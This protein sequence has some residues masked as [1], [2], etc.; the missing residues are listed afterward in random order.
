M[1]PTA[2][3]LKFWWAALFLALFVTANLIA[4]TQPKSD[5]SID[6]KSFTLENGM[7][8][9]VVHRPT[10]PQ[11]AVRL[12]VRAGSALEETGRTGIAHMLEHMLFKGTKNFGTTDWQRDAEL[13]AQIEAA[14]QVI[15]TEQRRRHPD[16]ALIQQKEAEMARLRAEVQQLYIPQAF[17]A[18]LG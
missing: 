11:V 5:L 18:Q 16:Q 10:T 9:L 13:Q 8:F 17:S 6:V 7:L 3:R 14:Y 12:A 4:A 15:K 1:K 2:T